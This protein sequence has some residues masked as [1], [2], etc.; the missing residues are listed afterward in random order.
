M[1]PMRP[2]IVAAAID[3]TEGHPPSARSARPQDRST[4]GGSQAEFVLP[5]YPFDPEEYPGLR[6]AVDKFGAR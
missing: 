5:R 1:P 4:K 3:L 6:S 2:P